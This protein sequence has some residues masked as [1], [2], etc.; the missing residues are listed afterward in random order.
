MKDV[1]TLSR[2]AAAFFLAAACSFGAQA[3][4][5]TTSGTLP[6]APAGAYNLYNFTVTSPGTTTLFLTGNTDA[7]LGL[8]SGTNVLSNATYL[9]QNDDS[10]GG[11]NSLIGMNLAAGN[12]TAWITSHGS[13]WDTTTN[14]IN[15]NHDHTPMSYTLTINGNVVDAS[16]VPE[17]GSLAL[18]GLG[19]VGFAASRRRKA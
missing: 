2:T 15:F 6:D 1:K 11:L 4:M 7:Y 8:F 12:Y 5:I 17:P 10:G 13:F 19:L 9:S 14:A 16:A 3:A 18:L